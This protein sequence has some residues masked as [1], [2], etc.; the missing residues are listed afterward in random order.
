MGTMKF[1]VNHSLSR[2]EAKKRIETLAQHW[3]SKYGFVTQW[4]GDSAKLAGKIMGLTI[5]AT[6]SI[7]DSKISGEGSDPGFLF[8]DKAKRYL[9]EKLT[10]ALDPKAK[11]TDFT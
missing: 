5:E 4:L 2:D 1:E 3:G 8:R 9:T 10:A 11:M 7:G 6:I